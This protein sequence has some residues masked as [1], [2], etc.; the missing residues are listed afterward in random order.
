MT[1]LTHAAIIIGVCFSMNTT[2]KGNEYIK[3]NARINNQP[4][5]LAFDTGADV[6]CLF[7]K[8]ANRLGLEVKEPPAELQPEPGKIKGGITN[9]CLLEFGKVSGRIRFGVAD[10]PGFVNTKLDGVIGWGHIRH[11]IVEISY[12]PNKIKFHDKLIIDR[13][14]WRCY[15]ICSDFDSL[16]M[17]IPRKR[18][19]FTH[20]LIDTGSYAG[21]SLNPELWRQLVD[22]GNKKLTLSALFSPGKGVVISEETWAQRLVLEGIIFRE[23]PVSK[24]VETG[25]RIN[26]DRGLDATLGLYALS[27]F[28]WIIDGPAGHVY[29][30]PNSLRRIPEKYSY[31]RLGAVLYTA[32]LKQAMP[33]SDALSSRAP[34]TRREYAMVTCCSESMMWM[35]PSGEQIRVSCR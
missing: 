5:L 11:N 28:S 25:K 16:V 7:S 32:I 3:I 26:V 12:A 21:A 22:S 23:V 33:W 2:G 20:V 29:L 18:G 9:E 34:R 35:Q 31:N 8:A 15:K 19:G 27:C 30:K 10:L 4:V 24:E 17:Q 6:S 1:K 13:S 14:L